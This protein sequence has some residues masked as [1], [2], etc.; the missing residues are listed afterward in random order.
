[1]LMSGT[2]ICLFSIS[3][4]IFYVTNSK[5]LGKT[6]SFCHNKNLPLAIEAT[7]ATIVHKMTLILPTDTL[8][9]LI[10]THFKYTLCILIQSLSLKNTYLNWFVMGPV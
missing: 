8:C 7:M 5:S 9:I 2:Y 4:I 10:V 6:G 1:M 3:S